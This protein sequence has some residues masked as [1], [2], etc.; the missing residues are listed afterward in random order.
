MS[1]T[2][3]NAA[4]TCCWVEA[5]GVTR[6]SLKRKREDRPCFFARVFDGKKGKGS[7]GDD[8]D[9]IA[10][11]ENDELEACKTWKEIEGR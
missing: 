2:T 3:K 11:D 1:T 7:V 5:K 9:A 8:W 6:P 10:A 4:C